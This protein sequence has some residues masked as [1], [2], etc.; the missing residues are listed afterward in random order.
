M[1]PYIFF[2]FNHK[3]TFQTLHDEDHLCKPR[4]LSM[5][6]LE[7]TLGGLHSTSC[8]RGDTVHATLFLH[9]NAVRP[10]LVDVSTDNF[11]P[12]LVPCRN[13]VAF[14]LFHHP[15]K[16]VLHRQAEHVDLCHRYSVV[17][18]WN[19]WTA[20]IFPHMKLVSSPH[21]CLP[22]SLSF[23]SSFLQKTR[24]KRPQ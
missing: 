18:I 22:L 20:C 16:D 13:W 24:Q 2:L 9:T 4:G 5:G 12:H 1:Q 23:T 19:H 6:L 17:I 10:L 11:L 8:F 15:P 21:L 3:F 7:W 14:H